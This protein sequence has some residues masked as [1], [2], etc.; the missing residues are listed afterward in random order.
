[1][2][3]FCL[4]PPNP[5]LGCFFGLAVNGVFED[6]TMPQASSGVEQCLPA[7]NNVVTLHRD[8]YLLMSKNCIIINVY[9]YIIM[10]YLHST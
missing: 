7:Y 8:S 9:Y 1:M 5:V 2:T 10:I 6:L 4:Q 3:L